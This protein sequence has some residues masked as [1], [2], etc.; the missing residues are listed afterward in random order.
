[1]NDT[2]QITFQYALVLIAA[3]TL[4]A[5]CCA[6]GA[7]WQDSGLIQYR[8]LHNDIEGSLGLALSHPLFY[9][10]GIAAKCFG[11]GSFFYRVNLVSSIWA[12]VAVANLFLLLR[13][14]LCRT[15]PAAVAAI[16][17]A[18]SHTFWRHASI[19]ETYTMYTA[20]LLTELIMLLQYGKTKRM[21]YL[22][23]LALLNGLAVSVHMLG[24]I[25]FAC[26]L[27]FTAVLLARKE[28]CWRHL[29]VL[30]VLWMVGAAAYEY[31]II[32]SII[33]TGDVAGTLASAAFGGG[34]SGEGYRANVLNASVS[35]TIVKENLL[36]VLLNF[37]TPNILLAFVGFYGVYKLSPTGGFG[38]VLLCVMVLFFAFAF[39]YTIVDRYAF[40]IPFYC[41][42]SVAAGVGAH[43]VMEKKKC[44][45]LAVLILLLA[46]MP[47]PVYAVA[48]GLA[49]RY[50]PQ[51]GQRRQIPY[52]DNYT[53]FL[54][55]WKTGYEGADL[56]AAEVLSSVEKDAVIWADTTT[57]FALLCTQEIK[58]MRSDVKVITTIAASSGAP[59][60]DKEHI[61]GLVPEKP[62]Y[63]VSPLAGYCPKFLLEDYDFV[64][65]GPVWRVVEKG[66]MEKAG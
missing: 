15:W 55:P 22:Y 1:M 49:R 7:L 30:S 48:P 29:I 21:K 17:F 33:Q 62:V 23:L 25:P 41:M 28:I 58:G 54:Q 56:F 14:W 27:V 36:F 64:E 2:R 10:A 24:V 66:D 9:I 31:L 63:V 35:L 61:A 52:R 42:M 59:A 34:V 40:F 65:S 4:Y 50:C 60:F 5:I 32:K 11:V 19:A 45:R 57:A 38:A 26:Y 3:I 39:R 47:A 18:L 51:L 44:R 12:A 20:F 13:L 46:L 6:P 53:Y 37:P 16:M 8:I 43:I